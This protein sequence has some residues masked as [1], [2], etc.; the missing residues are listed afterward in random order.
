MK[1]LTIIATLVISQSNAS[2]Q[3]GTTDQSSVL[4]FRQNVSES[5]H[6]DFGGSFDTL[7]VYLNNEGHAPEIIYDAFAENQIHCSEVKVNKTLRKSRG[8][9]YY[10]V[11]ITP[12]F[13]LEDGQNQCVVQVIQPSGES[14]SITMF[15]DITE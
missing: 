2:A 15:F 1:I 13:D 5:S 7:S 11:S 3:Q 4:D 12:F 9:S 6:V 8:G 14:A 10:I